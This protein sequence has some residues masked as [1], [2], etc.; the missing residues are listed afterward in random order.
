MKTTYKAIIQAIYKKAKQEKLDVRD[1][2]REWIKLF[3][4][5]RVTGFDRSKF[6]DC[7]VEESKKYDDK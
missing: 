5:S 1:L 7:C 6:L 4:E 3:E 2:I